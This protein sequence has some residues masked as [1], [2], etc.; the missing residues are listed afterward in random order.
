VSSRRVLAVVAHADDE[1][2]GCGGTLALHSDLQDEVRILILTDSVGSRTSDKKW[3][4]EFDERRLHAN[5]AAS[6]V[7]AQKI[8]FLSFPDNKMDSIPLLDIVKEVEAYIQAFRPTTIYTHHAGDL[9]IDHQLTLRATIT[10]TR[11]LPESHVENIFGFEVPS[12]TEWN[13]PD[14]NDA[15]RPNVFV[16]ISNSLPRKL[17][18]LRAYRNEIRQF[19]HPR[20][21][22]TCESLARVRGSTSGFYAAEAFTLLRSIR[23]CP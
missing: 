11:P 17:D 8:D 1:I 21:I 19:P 16:D 2:L 13:W 10:A 4:T 3:E 5:A 23:T 14:F 9:N 18:A 15:F 6:V 7:G 12:S 22:E 20:S